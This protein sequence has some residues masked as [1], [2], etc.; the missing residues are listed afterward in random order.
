MSTFVLIHG[1]WHHGDLWKP[2]AEAL[3]ALGHE[4]HHPTVGGNNEGDDLTIGHAE[5]CRPVI[6]YLVDQDLTGV[7]L[8]G[9][10]YGG[11]V[12]SKMAEAVPERIARL[13]YSN[14][15]VCE[16]GNSVADEC[17]PIL[18][19]AM[20]ASADERGDGGCVLPFVA[21]RE[22]FIQDADIELARWSFEQLRPHPVA[23]LF[24]KLDLKKFYSLE[25]PKSFVNCTEDMTLTQLPEWGWHPRMSSRLG[26]FRL[27]QMPGTHEVMFSN[28]KGLADALH[29]AGRD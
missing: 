10:S 8:V 1:G 29:L 24:D 15:F 26:L 16:D 7:V 3:R 23:T 12:I 19:D 6:D 25:I 22:L 13:V 11:S 27:V 28:P 17:P 18:R 21:W 2:T 9:H 20:K 5:A 14:A 4:V